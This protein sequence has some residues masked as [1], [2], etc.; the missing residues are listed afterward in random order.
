MAESSDLNSVVQGILEIT[1]SHWSCTSV[2]IELRKK[3]GSEPV[4][5]RFLFTFVKRPVSDVLELIFFCIKNADSFPDFGFPLENGFQLVADESISPIS[6]L[7]R[8]NIGLFWYL[9]INIDLRGPS[10]KVH[11]NW[12]GFVGTINQCKLTIASVKTSSGYLIKCCIDIVKTCLNLT[13]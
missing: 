9:H 11:D 5:R 10:W 4:F 13:N 6:P 2:F 7:I 8:I 12:R 3:A 1:N